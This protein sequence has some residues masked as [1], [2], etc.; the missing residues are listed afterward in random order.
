MLVG[1][2]VVV[3]VL[4]FDVTIAF[5]FALPAE[6]TVADLAQEE[7]YAA[8]YAAQD[9][10]IHKTAFGTIDNPDVQKEFITSNRTAAARECRAQFPEQVITESTPFRFN[11]IDLQPRY[12]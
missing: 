5:E 2:I 7:H 9:E 4:L 10:E 3:V 1:A 8:C 12:W 11:L 6:Q